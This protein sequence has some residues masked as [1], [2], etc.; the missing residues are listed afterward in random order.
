M[1]ATASRTIVDAFPQTSLTYGRSIK[2]ETDYDGIA[3]Q[4][5]TLDICLGDEVLIT[6]THRIDMGDDVAVNHI[7]A[8]SKKILCYHALHRL[9]HMS[10]ML[11]HET[12]I[13]QLS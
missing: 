2:I 8:V 1:N 10:H 12:N 6:A 5:V 11:L 13:G 9:M 7:T 4:S 3:Y